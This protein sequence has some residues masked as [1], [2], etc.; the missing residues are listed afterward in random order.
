MTDQPRDS[1][2]WYDPDHAHDWTRRARAREEERLPRLKMLAG[3]IP[4]ERDEAISV[5][6]IGAG[7]G[8]LS[9][10]IL[11]EFPRCQMVWHDFSEVMETYAH[12]HLERFE[13][14]VHYVRSDLA[15]PDW[16]RTLGGPFH[17]VVSA[18]AIH[19]VHPQQRIPFIY[20][21]V[22]SMVKEGGCFLN[23][24][25]VGPSGPLTR[26]L[27]HL[28]QLL[29]RQ[30][31]SRQRGIEKSLVELEEEWRSRDMAHM[32]QASLESQL[33]WLRQ[34]GFD[35]VDCLWKDIGQAIIGG[36]RLSGSRSN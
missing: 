14:R 4:F 27:Y 25:Y 24:E 8:L 13:G 36:Y 34:A 18:I 26:K 5:L 33:P 9:Q 35:E 2:Q 10:V 3:F 17:A 31:Q 20:R 28:H 16:G 22:F 7:Y 29:S 11:E 21:E 15:N 32:Q 23:S 19:D 1:H 30:E 12:Q 6:D